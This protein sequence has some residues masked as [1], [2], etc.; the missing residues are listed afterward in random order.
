[1]ENEMKMIITWIKQND[2]AFW[3]KKKQTLE[4]IWYM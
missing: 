1:M 2:E 3:F 4:D